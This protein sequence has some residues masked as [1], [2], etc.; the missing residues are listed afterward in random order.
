MDW[1]SG[2]P[3]PTDPEII[4]DSIDNEIQIIT[5]LGSEKSL[6][7]ARRRYR[8]YRTAYYESPIGTKS[9]YNFRVPLLDPNEN[10]KQHLDRVFQRQATAFKVRKSV[11]NTMYCILILILIRVNVNV[12]S[13]RSIYQARYY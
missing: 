1:L 6:E 2:I 12:P 4:T 10:I 9:R 5:S 7:V 11:I 13:F 3:V 8:S